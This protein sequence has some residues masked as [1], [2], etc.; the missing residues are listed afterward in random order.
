MRLKEMAAYKY[1]QYCRLARI[2][3]RTREGRGRGKKY[4]WCF[5]SSESPTNY[6]SNDEESNL[7]LELFKVKSFELRSGGNGGGAGGIREDLT[8]ESFVVSC[9]SLPPVDTDHDDEESK[10]ELERFK[11]IEV[12][13]TNDDKGSKLELENFKDFE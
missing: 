10:L 8:R 2:L 1:I 5:P 12:A 13:N 9:S 3:F 6:T 4:S 7:K 11:S